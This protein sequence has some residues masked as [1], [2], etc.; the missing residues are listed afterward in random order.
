MP[1]SLS[2]RIRGLV[3]SAGAR[4]VR[5]QT[6]QII[7]ARILPFVLVLRTK[8]HTTPSIPSHRLRR[9]H[10]VTYKTCTLLGPLQGPVHLPTATKLHTAVDPATDN[11][12]PAKT[13]DSRSLHGNPG[14]AQAISRPG[15]LQIFPSGEFGVVKGGATYWSAG[16]NSSLAP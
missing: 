3:I 5:G 12:S 9:L 1:R 4:A 13:S 15:D 2:Q 16:L 7:L 8:P 14:W 6:K 10:S 11:F